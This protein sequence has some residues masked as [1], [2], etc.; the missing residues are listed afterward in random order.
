[1]QCNFAGHYVMKKKKNILWTGALMVISEALL[2]GFVGWWITGQYGEEKGRLKNELYAQF[3]ES[4]QQVMDSM[5]LANVIDP[6]LKDKKGFKVRLEINDS[7]SGEVT[8]EHKLRKQ[9]KPVSEHDS[10]ILIDKSGG[11]FNK[12]ITMRHERDSVHEALLHGVKLFIKE[13]TTDTNM[14]MRTDETFYYNTDT[15]MLKKILSDNLAKSGLRFPV[16]WVSA[17]GDSLK[18]HSSVMYFESNFFPTAY[19]AE[20]SHY[21][22]YLWK[23]ITP[24]ILFA[25]VLLL[26]T[27]GAFLLSYRNLKNQMRLNTLKN[28]FISNIS[29]ELKTPVT[30]VKIAIEALQHPDI[31]N[32]PGKVEDYL[33]M[34]SLEMER[35]VLLINKVLNTSMAEEGRQF[36]QP[37]KINLAEL[38]EEVLQSLQL[39][40]ANLNATVQFQKE[41]NE[42]YSTIDKLHVQ[43]VLLNLIDNSLKYGTEKPEITI[44]LSQVNKEIVL[45]ITDNGPGIPGEYMDKVFDKFFRV[46]SGN[47][48]NVKGHGLG[49]SYASLVMKH[50]NGTIAVKNN[51]VKGCTLTLTFPEAES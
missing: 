41:T 29:H 42:L 39:R 26:L 46:P 15:V 28:D 23:K 34:A 19:G 7:V 14:K 10:I 33:S 27:G 12:M 44:H 16:A 49:L 13:V 21:N 20:I 50:H 3:R 48:H 47:K 37:E 2:T 5:L 51:P 9:L 6:L 24:Q 32:E 17:Q 31:K 4:K 35:L 45:S 38:V 22:L 1:M 25:L 36:F 11:S 43:G 8:P 30:T 18:K 40:F